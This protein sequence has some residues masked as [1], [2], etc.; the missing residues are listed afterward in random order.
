LTLNVPSSSLAD[1]GSQSYSASYIHEQG[2]IPIVAPFDAHFDDFLLN[3]YYDG[4]M[5]NIPSTIVLND[6]GSQLVEQILPSYSQPDVYEYITYYFNG[7][8]L[9]LEYKRGN[10]SG[11]TKNCLARTIKLYYTIFQNQLDENLNLLN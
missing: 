11:E 4:G 8:G 10:F 6:L 7:T 5:S 2:Q 3:E 1:G 9:Y